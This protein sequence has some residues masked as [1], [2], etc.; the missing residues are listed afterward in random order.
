MKNS[1]VLKN[2]FVNH[3]HIQPGALK[4]AAPTR[5]FTD[6]EPTLPSAEGVL[7]DFPTTVFL[8]RGDSGHR[9]KTKG[10]TT[11]PAFSHTALRERSA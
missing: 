5:A 1:N 11:G 3:I 7:N 8:L 9:Y 6:S 2:D 4:L 10:R